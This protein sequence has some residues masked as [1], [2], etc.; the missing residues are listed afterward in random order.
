MAPRRSR[1]RSAAW[2]LIGAAACVVSAVVAILMWSAMHSND[3][4]V[5]VPGPGSDVVSA[6]P[7]VPVVPPITTTIP[8][9][10]DVPPS[11]AF[12]PPVT[13]ASP[14][15][16]IVTTDP[17]TTVTS[18]GRDDRGARRIRS[19]QREDRAT[20]PPTAES[21]PPIPEIAPPPP[22][23]PTPHG[24]GFLSLVTSPWTQVTVEGRALG[25]TPLVRAPLPAGT[26]TLRL[27]NSEAGIDETYEITI[28]SGETTSR[29]L[30]LR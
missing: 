25:E 18:S 21:V 12:A 10:A 15:P 16:L 30:G 6:L 7:P 23:E 13:T 4:P 29:R 24:P 28:R 1:T 19:G 14:D 2:W 11:T 8:P 3:G 17:T 26:H 20:P 5:L 22:S 9:V 27:R